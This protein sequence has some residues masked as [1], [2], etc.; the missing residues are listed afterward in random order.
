MGGGANLSSGSTPQGG[1][2]RLR[3]DHQRL[4]ENVP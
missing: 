1:Y 3:L 2:K 4:I